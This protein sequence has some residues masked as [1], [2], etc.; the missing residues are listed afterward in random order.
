[1]DFFFFSKLFWFF[2]A[3]SHVIVWLMVAGAVWP[4]RRAVRWMTGVAAAFFVL[5]LFVP[6]G[7]WALA[8]LENQ[9]KR[10]PWPAHVDG[11]L[12]LGGGLDAE[13][14]KSRGVPGGPGEG[15]TVTAF[16]LARRYPDARIVFS[17][18]AAPPLTPETLAARQVF[19]QLG[20]ADGRVIYEGRSRDTWE[21]FVYSQKLVH[22]KPGETW[23]LVTSAWHMP[24]AMAIARRVGWPMQPW[25]SD[26]AT[27]HFSFHREEF[28]SNL[29]NLD[30]AAHEWVGLL[31]YRLS[32]RAR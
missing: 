14:F 25:P 17:G 10:P 5:Q 7:Y 8:L 26:Y 16:E 29:G 22:P 3:P 13:V 27:G 32:G 1:M 18:G 15:R 20:V 4:T 28:G 19:D 24:R 12:E 11:V 6:V 9:Y 23:L 2:A 21:N 30:L 31:A